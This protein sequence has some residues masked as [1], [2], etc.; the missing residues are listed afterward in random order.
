MFNSYNNQKI[1]INAVRGTIMKNYKNS[2][3]ERFHLDSRFADE[4]FSEDS[5]YVV[6]QIML[7]GDREVIAELM[8]KSDFDK[9]FEEDKEKVKV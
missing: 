2:S 7:C 4:V 9:L 8:N 5:K 3:F 6:L 1:S